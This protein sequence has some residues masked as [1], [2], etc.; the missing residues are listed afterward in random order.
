MMNILN[1]I[2]RT[3]VLGAVLAGFAITPA[4]ANEVATIE[5]DTTVEVSIESIKNDLEGTI[6]S[7]KEELASFCEANGYKYTRNRD[8]DSINGESHFIIF[9]CGNSIKA[10]V[11][12]EAP[13]MEEEVVKE[14]TVVEEETTVK[15]ETTVEEETVVEEQP[16][17]LGTEEE[18]VETEVAEAENTVQDEFNYSINPKTG[19]V[20][21]TIYVIVTL[22]AVIGLFITRK[23]Q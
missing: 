9:I 10:E 13:K 16:E 5:N 6:F 15:E 4:F 18:T 3:V 14:E 2:K 11:I 23:F 8:K 17:V 12:V 22:F 1:K 7:S 20:S 21:I 19:D